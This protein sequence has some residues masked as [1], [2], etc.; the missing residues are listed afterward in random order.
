MNKLCQSCKDG[1]PTECTCNITD[2]YL[3]EFG[4]NL[5]LEVTPIDALA[6]WDMICAKSAPKKP[7]KEAHDK[8]F[9]KWITQAQEEALNKYNGVSAWKE[10][11]K[12]KGYWKYFEKETKR[13]V[14]EDMANM[15]QCRKCSSKNSEL[16]E[17]YELF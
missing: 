1:F 11:G 8:W 14:V 6:E 4:G 5:Y 2:K 15:F 13:D 3:E 16:N 9:E 17:K 12:C 7:T 10:E